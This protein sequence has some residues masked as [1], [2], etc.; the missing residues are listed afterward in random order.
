MSHGRNR[1]HSPHRRLALVEPTR[2]FGP[3]VKAGVR[4]RAAGGTR[5]SWRRHARGVWAR[6]AGW[7]AGSEK[8]AGSTCSVKC[9]AERTHYLGHR[10]PPRSEK[11]AGRSRELRAIS[12]TTDTRDLRRRRGGAST[13][14]IEEPNGVLVRSRVPRT[15]AAF[16][17]GGRR[18]A[19]DGPTTTAARRGARSYA[20]A[21]RARA[22]LP[23]SPRPPRR[24]ARVAPA[25]EFAPY[26]AV[27]GRA[28]ARRVRNRRP[29]AALRSLRE[30]RFTEY[31][32]LLARAVV[33]SNRPR[34]GSRTVGLG[35]FRKDGFT[36]PTERRGPAGLNGTPG[37]SASTR[38][39]QW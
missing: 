24:R 29:A 16:E 8:C 26:V 28:A 12:D 34:P 10:A 5:S 9:R 22:A 4:A 15:G 33:T 25:R 11:A 27:F 13:G 21:R 14:V 35:S 31:V 3:F 18:A 32:R 17:R 19:G 1:A 36:A 30:L 23:A 39:W 7:M 2:E 20:I 38:N 37:R 6:Q